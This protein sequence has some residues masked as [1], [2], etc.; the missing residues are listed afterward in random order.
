M[1]VNLCGNLPLLRTKMLAVDITGELDAV[2]TTGLPC[3]ERSLGDDQ[4]LGGRGLG[5][6]SGLSILDI[7]LTG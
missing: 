4:S 1:R 6:W 3:L 5:A 7:E 2:G